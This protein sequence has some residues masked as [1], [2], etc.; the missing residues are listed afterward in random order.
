MTFRL[1]VT[2][3]KCSGLERHRDSVAAAVTDDTDRVTPR[4]DR[5]ASGRDTVTTTVTS[6]K[7]YVAVVTGEYSFTKA[8]QNLLAT[9]VN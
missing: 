4:P 3:F 6:L 2:E 7:L 1:R 9:S 8:A 5:A